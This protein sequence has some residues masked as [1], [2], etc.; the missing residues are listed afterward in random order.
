MSLCLFEGGVCREAEL[1]AF[2]NDPESTVLLVSMRSGGGAA[3]LTL[4]MATYGFILEPSLNVGIE[5]QAIGRLHRIG[6]RRDVTVYRLLTKN[7][8][9]GKIIEMQAQKRRAAARGSQAVGRWFLSQS[10]LCV[11]LLANEMVVAWLSR[12]SRR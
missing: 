12:S 2:R 5:D 7:T 1:D 11:D 10:G 6:Q 4:T 3:G 8:I 9:E